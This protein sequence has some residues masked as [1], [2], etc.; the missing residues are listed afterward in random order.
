MSAKPKKA[1]FV[2]PELTVVELSIALYNAN[3]KLEQTNKELVQI[4]KEQAEVYANISHDLRSPITAIKN[5]ME[6]LLTLDTFDSENFLPTINL[7]HCRVNYLEQLINDVFLLSSI[8]SSKNNLQFET[9]NIGMFLEDFFF[10][11]DADRKYSKRRLYLN[12]PEDFPYLVSIDCRMLL[13][14]MDNLFSNAL[15]Y[16]SDESS[17]TLSVIST[18]NNTIL[19]SVADT[20]FGIATEHFNIIFDR[21]YMVSSA[22]TPGQF[23]GC[24]LGLAIAKSVIDNHGGNIWCESELGKGSIF[25]FTLPIFSMC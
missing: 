13:R 21:S 16:S 2:K 1:V 4:Q 5:S 22:R 3:Q 14:V 11:C 20:G 8:D 25:K 17:I 7:M 24:G 23:S 10:S 15:K 9:V 19:I 12:V 18:Q 6:Y